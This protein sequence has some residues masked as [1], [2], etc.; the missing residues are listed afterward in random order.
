MPTAAVLG[1]RDRALMARRGGGIIGLDEVGRGSLAGPVVVC[2]ARFDT[3][4]DLP[5]VRDSKEVPRRRRIDLAARIRGAASSWGTVE[6]W[7]EIIDDINI[8]QAVRA[9]MRT[10]IRTLAAPDDV[11]VCDAVDPFDG[12]DAG[13]VL[14]APKADRDYFAVAAASLVA[15]VLRDET[16]GRLAHRQPWWGWDHNSGYG[17]AEHRS[18]L[19]ERGRSYLHRESFRVMGL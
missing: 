13:R 18:R 15:K 19:I 1:A 12:D 16:M 3:L 6:M 7:P 2:G 8:L 4:P 14:A 10:L 17:T 11:V 9:A 5:E